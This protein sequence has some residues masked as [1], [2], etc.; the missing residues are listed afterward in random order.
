M[1]PGWQRGVRPR[2]CRGDLLVP[3]LGPFLFLLRGHPLDDLGL[4]ATALHR[5]YRQPQMRRGAPLDALRGQTARI[6][7]RQ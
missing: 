2:Q 4:D 6:D 7:A 1:E 5:R 3:Q